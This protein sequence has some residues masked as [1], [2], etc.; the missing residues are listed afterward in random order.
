M[1]ITLCLSR[2]ENIDYY[3]SSTVTI[4]I[5][6]YL[7]GV[8]PAEIGNA[9][10]EACRAQ[11]VAS[12]TFALIKHKKGSK[13]TDKSSSDQAFRISKATSA[14]SNALQAIEDTKGQ[15]LYYNNQLITTCSY[16]NSNGGRVKSSKEVWGGERAWLVS[17][18]DPYDHGPGNGHGVGMSQ[19]GAKEMA[20][21]G[22][23]YKQI[24][25]FYYPGTNIV[26]NYGDY[27]EPEPEVIKVAYQAKI[28]ASSG[29]TVNMRETPSS[30]ARVINQVPVGQVV[31]VISA[32]SDWS[33]IMYKNKSGYMM[34]KF[35]QK[36]ES[37]EKSKVWYVRIEC[38]SEEQAKA[39]AQALKKAE[40]TT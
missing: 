40:A 36:V 35:L 29:N 6:E 22:F 16:S 2:K 26:S 20:N 21:Q 28:I 17:K 19:C 39:I 14:Y 38:D 34:S 4:D 5:E 8:I 7:R 37:S 23:N 25:D 10:I 15:V 1:K 12:R 3:K 27:R 13:I 30:S 31:D 9:S 24:L 11:A 32:A 33:Q 18:P